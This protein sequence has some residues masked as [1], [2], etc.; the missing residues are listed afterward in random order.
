M[1][2]SAQDAFVAFTVANID[3]AGD[4]DMDCDGCENMGQEFRRC[5]E[6]PC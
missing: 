5:L 1:Q 2:L 3:E 4:M 6:R